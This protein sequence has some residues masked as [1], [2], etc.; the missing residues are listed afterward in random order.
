MR[1]NVSG[2]FSLAE[3]SRLVAKGC[4]ATVWECSDKDER[5]TKRINMSFVLQKSSEK[6]SKKV[7]KGVDKRKEA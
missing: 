6:T 4:G 5:K 3:E 1:K 7:K 2:T